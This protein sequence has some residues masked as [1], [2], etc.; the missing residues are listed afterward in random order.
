MSIFTIIYFLQKEHYRNLHIG[1]IAI[2]V[3]ALA[4]AYFVEYILHIPPCP[5]CIYERFPYLYLIKLSLV[6]ILVKK[7]SK[8]TLMFISITLL[9]SCLLASY[10]SGIERGIFGAS[11]FCA[12]LLHIPQHLSLAEIKAMIY[13]QPIVTCDKAAFKIFALSMAEW[14]LIL[15]FFLFGLVA[16]I[17]IKKQQG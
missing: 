2:S 5:L 8:Y 12:S 11:S 6:G 9:V 14:N 16:Y 17:Q 7:T 10:H 3:I 15:N 1:L 4:T 13:S